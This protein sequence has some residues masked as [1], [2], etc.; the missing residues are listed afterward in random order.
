[1]TVEIRPVGVECNLACKY[2]YQNGQREASAKRPG[3]SFDTVLQQVTKH[4]QPF[5]VFG[6]EALLLPIADL[7][8][9]FKHGFDN[10]GRTSIQSNGTLITK[11]YIR[12]F[13]RYNVSIG[14]SIDGPGELNDARWVRNLRKTRRYTARSEAAITMLIDSGIVPGLI[15]TLHRINA[16]PRKLPRLLR[17]IRYLD[18]LGIKKVRLHNLQVDDPVVA[19]ELLLDEDDCRAAFV[20]LYTLQK[21]LSGLEFDIFRDIRDLLM[22]KDGDASCVWKACDPYTTPAVQ[23]IEGDGHASN[24]DRTNKGGIPF[25]KSTEER[26]E[27]YLALY[28]TPQPYGGCR[29]CRFFMFCKGQCPGTAIDADWRNRSA[30]CGL[31]KT[32]FTLVEEEFIDR[33]ECPLSISRM[34]STIEAVLLESW[35]QGINMPLN[36]ALEIAMACMK[37]SNDSL[38]NVDVADA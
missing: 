28:H 9:L 35:T 17:W 24:C 16:A 19:E 29:G 32:L 27:R 34:R 31:W 26:H 36:L 33:M 1:M 18:S 25:V 4:N 12:L 5:T 10:F 37:G 14:I 23:G 22:G 20:A 3:F 6:G 11:D 15:I 2:C 8:K 38:S 30:D 21:E 7:E 13:R